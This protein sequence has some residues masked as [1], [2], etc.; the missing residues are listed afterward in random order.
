MNFDRKIFFTQYREQ[1]KPKTISQSQ[2]DGFETLLAFIES[3]PDLIDRRHIAYLLATVKHECADQWKPIEEFA[4]GVKMEGR[5]DLGNINPGDGPRFKGRGYVQITGRG[6]YRR[7]AALL[8]VDLEGDPLL[9]L[10]PDT[11]Y[12]IASLGMRHGLFTGKSLSTF[13][14]GDHVDYRNARRIINGLDQ[15]DKIKGHAEKFQTILSASE[16]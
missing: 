10:V 5:K 7:F 1:F 4:S 11:S 12:Q 13:I 3:D 9:A 15:A 8:G 16:I 6:N 14:H 2:V